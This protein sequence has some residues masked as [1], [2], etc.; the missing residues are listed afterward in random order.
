[1]IASAAFNLTVG[2][3]GQPIYDGTAIKDVG[4]WLIEV[5]G[6]QD[7]EIKARA[8]LLGS[9]A[10]AE[11]VKAKLVSENFSSLAMEYSQHKS[12]DEGGELGLLKQGAMNSTAFDQVAFNLPLNEVSGPVK[13]ESVQT[14]GGYWLVMVVDRGEHQ[15][16]TEVR[17]ELRDKHMNVWFEEW[18]KDS[19]IDNRLDKEK[20]SWAVDRV[21]RGR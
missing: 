14:K 5:T 9:E 21:L 3:I 6:K 17:N 11:Q 18:K 13:D 2:E 1:L 7:D 16:E 15:L 10:E 12:K 19:T 4:Y 20:K 8:M